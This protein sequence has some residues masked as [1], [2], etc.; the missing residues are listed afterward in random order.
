M[1]KQVRRI[2]RRVLEVYKE[3]NVDDIASDERVSCTRGCNH[4]CKR[5]IMVSLPE[6]IAIAERITKDPYYQARLPM[7]MRMLYKQVQFLEANKLDDVTSC[8]FLKEDGD[9]GIYDFRPSACRYL[10]VVSDPENCKR[11]NKSTV[12][13]V[14]MTK[15]EERVWSEG[16]RLSKQVG[17]PHPMLAPLPVAILWGMK[18]L[19]EG[20]SGFKF[21]LSELGS[22]L[23][24]A[25]WEK[26]MRAI[27]DGKGE[28]DL[29]VKVEPETVEEADDNSK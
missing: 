27:I 19:Q 28:E 6:G 1:D 17:V 26:R 10:F 2:G 16:N 9:C 5:M 20:V 3:Q 24:P 8:M 22:G 21:S 23:H 14:D 7:F 12:S 11:D 15:E 25:Y 29:L 13:R 4:C 18:I